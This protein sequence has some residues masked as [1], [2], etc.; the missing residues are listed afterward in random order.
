MFVEIDSQY[1]KR[2][3]KNAEQGKKPIR[4]RNGKNALYFTTLIKIW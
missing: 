1:K 3:S 2:I 4:T